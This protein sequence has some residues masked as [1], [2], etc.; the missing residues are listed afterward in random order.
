MIL[1][2][3]KISI[4]KLRIVLDVTDRIIVRYISELK[5]KG[6]IEQKGSAN[7]GEWKVR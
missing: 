1:E 2:N 7:G 3:P 5:G 4:D 6:I